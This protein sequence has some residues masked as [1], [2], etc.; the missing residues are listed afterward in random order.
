VILSHSWT[1][2]RRHGCDEALESGIVGINESIISSEMTPFG[3]GKESGQSREGS[4]YG[5][6][7][8]LE[9]KYKCI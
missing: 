8:Y 7:D 1:R 3:G 6:D 4:K 2:S 5:L 9:I